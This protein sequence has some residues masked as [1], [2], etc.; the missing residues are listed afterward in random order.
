[1]MTRRN[2]TTIFGSLLSCAFLG[3]MA[4]GITV[5]IL[6]EAP[7]DGVAPQTSIWETVA[8]P[9]L[10]SPIFAVDPAVLAAM[11]AARTPLD[12]RSMLAHRTRAPKSSK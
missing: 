9:Q 3:V 6:D 12:S 1:M 4:L 2:N 8:S 11:E 5:D 10:E 7:T